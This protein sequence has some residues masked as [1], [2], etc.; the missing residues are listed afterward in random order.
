MIRM[1]STALSWLASFFAMLSPIIIIH[2]LL[3]AV[4]NAATEPLVE[5]F[6]P[7]FDPMNE[8]MALFLEPLPSFDIPWFDINPSPF[9]MTPSSITI[10]LTEDMRFMTHTVSPV[11]GVL[12]L[13]FTGVFFVMNFIAD[14]LAVLDKKMEVQKNSRAFQKAIKE[15]KQLKEERMVKVTSNKEIVVYVDYSFIDSPTGGTYFETLYGRFEGEV[16]QS[17]PDS[18]ALRFRSLDKA[19]EYSK[20]STAKVLQYYETL[21]PIDPQPPFKVALIS[22]DSHVPTA[23]R[24]DFS[25]QLL[26][27]VKGNQIVLSKS[28]HDMLEVK[29]K[30]GEYTLVS[31]GIYKVAEMSQEIY[32][33]R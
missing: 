32:T 30:L 10:S 28:A 1:L 6:K 17:N 21:R 29:Q 23:E 22:F 14:M 24:F 3:V 13:W 15:G 27:F 19:I 31:L 33:I 4:D 9:M 8:T 18:I 11:Q 7:F 5:F 25:R 2:W 12:G 16:I 26:H 20:E